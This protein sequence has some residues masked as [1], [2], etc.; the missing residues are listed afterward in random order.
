MKDTRIVDI[1][2]VEPNPYQP[3]LEFDDE[4]LMDLAQS[5][6][7]NGLIQPITVREMDGKY[8]IIAGERRF[9]ALKLNGAV[10]VPVL[11]MDANEVQMAEMALVENIQ[12]ENLSAIEEA[13]SY[14]EIMKYSGLNQSQLALRVGKS[15]SSIANKIR[16]LNLDEDVQEAVSTKK[17]SERHARALI[18]LDEEKQHD[19][20]NKIVKKG[21]TVAQTEKMLKEQAQPKKEKKKV[22]L[23][24]ISKNIKIAINT[25]HQ[26][27]SMV[28]RAGTA[29]AISE[30]EHEDEVI[31]TIRIPK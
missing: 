14:V 27:V 4:A 5:I 22:M 25:I 31:I 24:G 21:M 12:R 29:A 2:L 9:R 18:G 11:I 19:A 15:Q 10:D 8:Q 3:R 6:R 30:E 7:E 16:L 26:A 28:N 17:I 20:L 23:K 1:D 13:K